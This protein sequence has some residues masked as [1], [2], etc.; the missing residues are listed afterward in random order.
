MQVA[1]K[2]PDPQ[3][4]SMM[5]ERTK[6]SLAALTQDENLLTDIKKVIMQLSQQG[7]PSLELTAAQLGIPSHSVHRYLVKLGLRFSQLRDEVRRELAIDY[8]THSNISLAEVAWNMG[9]A[10]YSAFSRAFK[11]WT[12]NTPKAYRDSQHTVFIR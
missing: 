8:L 2:Y 7:E 9:Y 10:E 3:L 1:L 5:L 6:N 11:R 12:G 4:V